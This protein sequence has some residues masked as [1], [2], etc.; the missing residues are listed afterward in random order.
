[1]KNLKQ[2]LKGGLI[3]GTMFA[4][5]STVLSGDYTFSNISIWIIVGLLVSFFIGFLFPF[6]L[7]KLSP[8]LNK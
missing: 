4:I 3:G 6:L 5:I 1:M 7:G 8:K 2:R